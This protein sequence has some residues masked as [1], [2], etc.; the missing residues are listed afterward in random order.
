MIC[1]KILLI[2]DEKDFTTTLAERLKLRGYDVSVASTADEA[3]ASVSQGI[4]NVIFMD[5]QIP[6]STSG[7]LLSALLK[8]TPKSR[9]VIL[10]GN[11]DEAT[12]KKSLE[13]GAYDYILKPFKIKEIVTKIVE[14]CQDRQE[15]SAV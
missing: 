3:L 11:A 2:D 8:V 9:I 4:P 7:E 14:A 10:T 6:G 5:L 15:P 13:Q 1:E 12:K